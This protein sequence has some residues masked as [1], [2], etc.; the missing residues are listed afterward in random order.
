MRVIVSRRIDF[1]GKIEEKTV[2]AET[3]TEMTFDPEALSDQEAAK[4][5]AIA[6]FESMDRKLEERE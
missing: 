2:E 4:A 6:L 3:D 1:N 5:M